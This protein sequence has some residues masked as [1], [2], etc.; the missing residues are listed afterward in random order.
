[1][2]RSFTDQVVDVVFSVA[3]GAATN[4]TYT[5]YIDVRGF[6]RGSLQALF[7]PGSGGGTL[8][9]KVYGS[10]FEFKHEADALTND[11]Y[12][13]NDI[14]SSIL[15]ATSKTASFLISDSAG[16]LGCFAWIKVTATLALTDATTAL[17]SSINKCS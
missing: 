16:L 1:M 3:A 10:S 6:R 9:Y 15:G 4:A 12:F 13:A 7:T 5:K 14:S 8:V 2:A 17:Y 11:A